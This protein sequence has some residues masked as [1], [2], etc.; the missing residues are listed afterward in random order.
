MSI[1]GTFPESSGSVNNMEYCKILDTSN[2]FKL[3]GF[4]TIND[5]ILQEMN[6]R[7]KSIV[8]EQQKEKPPAGGNTTGAIAADVASAST[9]RRKGNHHRR[10]S[11]LHRQQFSRM[12]SIMGHYSLQKQ[13]ERRPR[14]NDILRSPVRSATLLSRQPTDYSGAAALT[15]SRLAALSLSS[16]PSKA[17]SKPANSFHFSK[18]ERLPN[19]RKEPAATDLEGADEGK[20]LAD[21]RQSGLILASPSKRRRMDLNGRKL[22]LMS[23]IPKP[24]FKLRTTNSTLY[25]PTQ[26]SVNHARSVSAGGETPKPVH[27]RSVSTGGEAKPKVSPVRRVASSRIPVPTNTTPTKTDT[28]TPTR[29]DEEALEA[30]M[31]LPPPPSAVPHTPV[32]KSTSTIALRTRSNAANIGTTNGNNSMNTGTTNTNTGTNNGTNAGNARTTN[33]STSTTNSATANTGVTNTGTSLNG[34]NASRVLHRS[35]SLQ[36]LETRPRW[37]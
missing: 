35:P 20:K 37:R 8:E 27:A 19:A 10:F 22:E 25:Q 30:M 5:K 26:A 9:P 2:A 11:S 34:G 21:K 23:F 15:S 29:A 18:A 33:I 6:A 7:A 36:R 3:K 4:E 1:P 31:K 14:P 32:R 17:T 28:T 13:H 16:S 12:D 24:A